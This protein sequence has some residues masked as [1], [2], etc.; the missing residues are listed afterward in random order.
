MKNNILICGLGHIGYRHIQALIKIKNI[1]KIYIYDK[2]KYRY[3]RFINNFNNKYKKKFRKILKLEK[4]N[5]KFFLAI[6]STT[7]KNRFNLTNKI[8]NLFKIKYFLIEKFLEADLKK[9]KLFK[10]IQRKNMFINYNWRL[11]PFIIQTKKIIRNFN[12]I[13]IVLDGYSWNM[14]SNA[15]HI[16]DAIK[17]I[18]ECRISSIKLGKD[19]KY[20]E[21]KRKGYNELLGTIWINLSNRIKLK[22]ISKNNKKSKEIKFY[23]R[24]LN[25]IYNFEKSELKIMNHI[26]KTKIKHVSETTA[27]IYK[28]MEKNNLDNLCS[29]SEI[30]DDS[31]QFLSELKKKYRDIKIT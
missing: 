2:K 5:L 22:L 1:N 27:L 15:L 12:K 29:L 6:I 28:K 9:L 24:K 17:S 3:E 7:S 19:I 16:V 4:R 21:S 18:F 26:K 25:I 8:N 14:A 30:I 11:Y 13:N 23:A 20:I 31:I 10:K